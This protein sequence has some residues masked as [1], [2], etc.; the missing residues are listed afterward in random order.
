MTRA[1]TGWRTTPPPTP[2]TPDSR[3]QPAPSRTSPSTRRTGLVPEEV[4]PCRTTDV[5]GARR[6]LDDVG[7][8]GG[9]D[10]GRRCRAPG[11]RGGRTRHELA[12]PPTPQRWQVRQ[13]A[14]RRR[15]TSP[16]ATVPSFSRS[17]ARGAC[18]SRGA[19]RRR[20]GSGRSVGID[21]VGAEFGVMRPDCSDGPAL[22][23]GRA[24]DALSRRAVP[25]AGCVAG[26]HDRCLAAVRSRRSSWRSRR[27]GTPPRCRR[28]R[29]GHHTG[30]GS[31]V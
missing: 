14:N 23:R 26:A 18:A 30:V 24:D 1:R 17:S 7:R 13:R 27:E 29:V 16:S 5:I 6:F 19:G 25:V 22:R 20:P 31:G 10:V 21:C 12:R 4:D 11:G 8:C 3:V 2:T 9:D 28:R 15:E